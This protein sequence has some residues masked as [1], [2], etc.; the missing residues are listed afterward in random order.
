MDV[1]RWGRGGDQGHTAVQSCHSKSTVMPQRVIQCPC[2][3]D[4][5]WLPS[6]EACCLLHELVLT[7]GSRKRVAFGILCYNPGGVATRSRV[8][9]PLYPSTARNCAAPQA[10]YRYPAP[11]A[12]CTGIPL[13]LAPSGV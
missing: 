3:Y 9:R 11:L 10:A 4:C 12:A 2:F 7:P 13:Q 1:G 6:P 5:L 8:P